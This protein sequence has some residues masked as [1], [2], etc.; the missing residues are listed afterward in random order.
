MNSPFTTPSVR[1]SRKTAF[2]PPVKRWMRSPMSSPE[3]TIDS[4]KSNIAARNS[5]FSNSTSATWK[6]TI[7]RRSDTFPRRAISFLHSPMIW[8][9][10]ARIAASSTSRFERK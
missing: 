2:M 9:V 4:T 3:R 1:S 5:F 8:R 6:H 7:P 10:A